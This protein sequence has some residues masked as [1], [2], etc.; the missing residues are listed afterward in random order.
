MN[1]LTIPRT[2]VGLEYKAV[3]YPAQLIETKVVAARL[4]EDHPVRLGYERFLGTLDTTA[5]KLLD[6]KTLADRGRVLTRRVDVLGKAV[7]LEAKAAERKAE[8]DA[9]FRAKNEQAAQEK[10]AIRTEHEQTA[11][12]LK[13]EREAEAKS[14]ERKAQARKRADDKAIVDST[15]AIIA[16]ER[17]RLDEQKAQIEARVQTQTAAP[18]AQLKDAAKNVQAASARRSDA[19]RLE[20]L[21]E[22]EKKKS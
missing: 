4:E 21:R 3:R 13:A 1:V 16:A 11:A 19:E 7:A 17:D 18:K 22:A 5:G 9:E 12:R 14:I 6:D 10:A 15:Q 20:S 8:A 2:I